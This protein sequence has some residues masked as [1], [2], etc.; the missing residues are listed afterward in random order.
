[1]VKKIILRIAADIVLISSLFFLPWLI[2]FSG[3][4][5]GAA[6]FSWYLEILAAG[7]LAAVL[8]GMPL[9]KLPFIFG[10][11]IIIQEWL[12]TKLKMDEWWQRSWLWLAGILSFAVLFLIL[13]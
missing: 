11:V 5:L 8:A 1:M 4:V 7:L 2:V 12:K 9:W 10:A 13:I 3:A 6:F